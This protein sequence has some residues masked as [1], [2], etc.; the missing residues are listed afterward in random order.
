VLVEEFLRRV[1]DFEVDE[2]AAVRLPSNFQ[3]GWNSIPVAVT[4]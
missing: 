2:S 4:A 3:W 1:R